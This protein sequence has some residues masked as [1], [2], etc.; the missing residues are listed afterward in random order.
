MENFEKWQERFLVYLAKEKNYSD[1]TIEGYSSDLKEFAEFLTDYFK[2]SEPGSLDIKKISRRVIRAWLNLLYQNL[3]PTSI[4]R[5]LASLRSFFQ[6]L[7]K[8][9]VVSHNP[10]QLVRSPKKDKRLPRVLS[11]EEVFALLEAPGKDD[12][13]SIRDRAILELFYASGIRVSELVGLN[14][15]DLI[16]DQR[17]IRV[18]GKGKKE[19]IIPVNDTAVKRLKEWLELRNKLAKSVLDPDAGKAVFLSREG[20]RI[21]KQMIGVLMKKYLKKGKLLRPATP[22]TLRHSFATHL[23][24][25]GMD[26]R[27]IQELLGHSSLST[28]Q[29]YTQVGLKELMEAYDDAHPRAKK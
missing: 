6:Y 20:K 11:P 16:L 18:M 4:E 25:S 9:G 15:E 19:R 12:P 27:S 24:D 5:H 13:I 22:H 8:E 26:I 23:L 28:T 10:A 17:L 7:V 21:S 29:R 14:L 3:T 2:L 1:K